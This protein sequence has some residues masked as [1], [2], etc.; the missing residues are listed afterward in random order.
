MYILTNES[1]KNF[2]DTTSI[3]SNEFVN[4]YFK[5]LDKVYDNEKLI[6]IYGKLVECY[7]NNNKVKVK[8]IKI[9]PRHHFETKLSKYLTMDGY[10]KNDKAYN[11]LMKLDYTSNAKLKFKITDNINYIVNAQI[12]H[13]EEDMNKVKTV[14]KRFIAITRYFA[15]CDAIKYMNGHK[16]NLIIILNDVNREIKNNGDKNI[17]KKNGQFNASSGYTSYCISPHITKLVMVCTK[18]PECLALLTHELGHLYGFDL[19]TL[20]I[21]KDMIYLS[22]DYECELFK[23]M[24]IDKFRTNETICN[25]NTTIIHSMCNSIESKNGYQEFKFFMNVEILYSIYHTAKILYVQ[26]FN[27]L[28]EFVNNNGKYVQSSYLFEYTIARSFLLLNFDKYVDILKFRVNENNKQNAINNIIN[29]IV[30][31][32]N[33][34]SMYDKIFNEYI[35]IVKKQDIINME[36]FCIDA[37]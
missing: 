4:D 2:I 22:G 36:Y 20:K 19:D 14:Y 11:E 26:G 27:N 7:D 1:K 9:D 32:M 35:K 37:L 29:L 3:L 21:S 24:G 28:N 6:N 17:Y 15:D 5:S 13:K 12:V 18:L 25:T 8:N 30:D 16:L 34:R 31:K 10:K 33:D 23:N